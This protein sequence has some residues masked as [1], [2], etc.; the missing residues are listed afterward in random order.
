MD[1]G[2]TLGLKKI[3]QGNGGEVTIYGENQSACELYYLDRAA[4]LKFVIFMSCTGE[5]L[6]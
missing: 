2:E 5:E 6:S 4:L 3:K 1:C